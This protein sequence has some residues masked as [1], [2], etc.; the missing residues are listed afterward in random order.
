MR[1]E[2]AAGGWTKEEHRPFLGRRG[3]AEPSLRSRALSSI[4]LT[5]PSMGAV[6]IKGKGKQYFKLREQDPSFPSDIPYRN[7]PDFCYTGSDENCIITKRGEGLS[8]KEKTLSANTEARDGGEPRH[9]DLLWK[10]LLARFF[11]PML[12]SLLPDL[13]EDIDDKRDVIFCRSPNQTVG[14]KFPL[15]GYSI[16]SA[17]AISSIQL[18]L[19]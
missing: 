13:A 5:A 17:W 10:D 11:V 15:S 18:F 7:S 6:S 19:T 12:Q 2:K 4:D 1:P 16:H 14:R 8:P 9:D 3:R